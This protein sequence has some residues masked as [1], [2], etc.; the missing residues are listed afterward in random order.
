M[1]PFAI[2]LAVKTFFAPIIAVIKLVPWKVYAIIA[3]VLIAYIGGKMLYNAGADNMERTKN[4]EIA[5]IHADYKAA[6]D[7]QLLANTI[8]E[9]LRAAEAASIK[10]N[11]ERGLKDAKNKADK[12]IADLT[13]GNLRL[14][15]QWR[16]CSQTTGADAS[17]GSADEEADLRNTDAGNL[18]RLAAEADTQIEALQAIIRSDRTNHTE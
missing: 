4:Q 5:A 17:T 14:R 10:A 13:T 2:P 9:K 11:Y 15:K 12:V 3:A 8:T 7:R 16:G 18:V 1:I 6:A